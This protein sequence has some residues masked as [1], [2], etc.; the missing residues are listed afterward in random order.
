MKRRRDY[1][2]G[3]T[4]A[5][6]QEIG[7]GQRQESTRAVSYMRGTYRLLRAAVIDA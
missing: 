4:V 5:V 2:K 3:I 7:V 1:G 6:R